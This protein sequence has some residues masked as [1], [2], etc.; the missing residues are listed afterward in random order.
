MIDNVYLATDEGHSFMEPANRD[1]PQV[2]F[3]GPNIKETHT[4]FW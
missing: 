2:S 4:S 1:F 3:G